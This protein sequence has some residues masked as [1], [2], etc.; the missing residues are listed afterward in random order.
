MT[1]DDFVKLFQRDVAPS[2]TP[3]GALHSD[4][5]ST[6]GSALIVN[7]DPPFLVT[8]HH[9][10]EAMLEAIETPTVKVQVGNL[11]INPK[12]R[13]KFWNREVDLATFELKKKEISLI[14]EGARGWSILNKSAVGEWSEE[15]QFVTYGFPGAFTSRGHSEIRSQGILLGGIVRPTA[16]G[17]LVLDFSSSDYHAPDLTE[18]EKGAYF[19]NPGGIS[20]SPIFLWNQDERFSW[21]GTVVELSKLGRVILG[22]SSSWILDGGKIVTGA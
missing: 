17:G 22:T 15:A 10:A 2:I 12:E 18:S 16:Q 21:I 9:V 1:L 20:G 3:L 5:N 19:K 8:N 4:G 13:L 6:L 11:R 14:F 7:G